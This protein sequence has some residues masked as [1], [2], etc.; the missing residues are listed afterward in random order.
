VRHTLGDP[1]ASPW[2]VQGKQLPDAGI[3]LSRRLFPLRIDPTEIGA[4]IEDFDRALPSTQR[5]LL[6]MSGGR[7][8]GSGNTN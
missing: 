8:P 2:Y 4:A 3:A 5:S 1:S 7:M 6:P